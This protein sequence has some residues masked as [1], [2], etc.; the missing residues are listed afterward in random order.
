M[1]AKL[2]ATFRQ[3]KEQ[4][5]PAFV[6][7]VTA[8][9][10]E[11]D[12]SVNVLLGMQAGGADVIEVGIPFTDPLAD[13]ATIQF[14]NEQALKNGMTLN[15]AFEIVE[16]A[17]AAGLTVPVVMM[18][19]CNPFLAM[20]YDKLCERAASVGVEGF[21]VVDLPADETKDFV[22]SCS[23]HGR[24]YIP[25]I[26]PTTTDER[27]QALGSLGTSF[28][29]VVSVAGVTGARA[30]VADSLPTFLERVKRLCPLPAAVGFGISTHEHVV[31]IGKFADGVVVGSAIINA[32]KAAED[33][34]EAARQTVNALTQSSSP[35]A[36]PVVTAADEERATPGGGLEIQNAV[37]DGMGKFGGRYIPETLVDAHEQ[38]EIMYNKT[39]ND[40]EFVAELDRLRREYVGG[41][42]PL[43]HASRLTELC[44]G[45][46]VWF[47][48][49]ELA[50]TGAHKI[51]NALGQCLL[52]KKLGKNRVIAETGAGQHGVATATAC[53]LL[54]LEAVVYMGAVDMERQ[55]LNV[56]KI[57]MLGAE[58]VGVTSGSKTLKDAINEAMRDWVT[59]V[60]TTH[61]CIG[62]AVGPHPFP[63]IVRDFQS[64]MGIEARA[65]ML[66]QA[67]RLPDKVVA[68]VGGGSNAIGIFYPFVKDETV[69]LIGVEAG[70]E[71]GLSGLHSATINSGKMGVL[72][73]TMT[74]VM[75][76][77]DGQ[78]EETHSVSAGLDYPAVGPEHAHLHDIGRAQY[79]IATDSQALEALQL[80]SRTEGIIPALETS[81]ALHVALEL[82]KGM[83]ADQ[84]ILIN[85]SG[86]GDKDMVS[87]AR[88]LG[89]D[90]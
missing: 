7:F 28:V 33:P 77:D 11:I 15:G 69:E 3:S 19:Y 22:G 14:A 79:L 78:I 55:A 30:A 75:Q 29:Y 67:G 5:R 13:G 35:V 53:A 73:G 34:A 66:A 56:F 46:R 10:P 70:G 27:M 20:G 8:G 48:R 49:E 65:Q 32:I 2:V 64:V 16:K 58:V 71:S 12:S 1:A 41:P 44:G 63:T 39:K 40:P 84:D 9:F 62:S 57:R 54:G 17:R 74:Y 87:V 72:H 85:I 38:L 24:S 83:S 6:G 42:T 81:H 59:N 45:A 23:K 90:V 31:E 36:P 21:I 86:R 89:V 82:A 68:C 37:K 26:T 18:G 61:Y 76:D 47:K 52:A 60:D 80:V 88:A 51:N 43:Y 50:H 4:G 25:L